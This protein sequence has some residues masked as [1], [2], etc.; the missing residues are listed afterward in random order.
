[1]RPAVLRLL[2]VVIALSAL[3]SPWRR[4]LYVGDETKY[5]QVIREMR[6]THQFFVPI[7]GGEP[8]AHKPPLHFWIVDLL[9]FPFGL[10]S[11]WPFVLPSLISFLALIWLVWRMS[12]QMLHG[13]GGGV[14]AFVA[15]SSVLIWGSAQT[16]RM[17][18]EFTVLLTAGVWMVRRFLASG[19]RPSL[20]MAGLLVA[21]AALDKGPMAPVIVIALLLFEWIRLRALPRGPYLGALAIAM[22]VPLFWVVPAF[23]IGGQRFANE[24]IMRQTVGRAVGSWVHRSPPWFYLVRSPMTL[25]PWCLLLI[26]AIA[27]V[28]RPGAGPA[29]LTDAEPRQRATGNGQPHGWTAPFCVSWILAVVVPYSLI[30]SKLDIYMMAAIP[31]LALLIGWL[32]GE[33]TRPGGSPAAER[34]GWRANAA[35]LLILAI[36]G[37]AGIV[38]APRMARGPEAALIPIHQV[39]VMFGILLVGSAGALVAVMRRAEGRLLR[40]TLALGIVVVATLAYPA[41]AMMGSANEIAST[42][43]LIRALRRQPVDPR[44]AALYFCPFLWSRDFPRDLERVRYVGPDIREAS[45]RLPAIL[46]TSRAHASEVGAWLPQYQKVDEL[47]MIGKWFDVYR[48]R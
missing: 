14:A 22:A 9:S 18:V 26:V 1:M 47:R 36:A 38:L 39:Q 21:I 19:D 31:P 28:Y 5:G 48:R 2:L 46:V 30:S 27:A 32:V 15:A 35:M 29:S 7:L 43:A 20:L 17:D 25:F 42:N 24:V 40:S 10:Y 4:E 44:D 41:T 6:T 33:A 11:I 13:A 12:D 34:W 3:I 37:A 45:G 23:L 16:A 8:F